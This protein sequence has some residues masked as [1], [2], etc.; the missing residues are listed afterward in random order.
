MLAT[1]KEVLIKVGQSEVIMMIKMVAPAAALKASKPKGNQ[2]KGET[3]RNICTIGSN[4]FII[5]LDD[6]IN[7]PSGMAIKLPKPKPINTL[8]KELTNWFPMPL[9][10]GP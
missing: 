3:G 6:P 10:L 1:P 4:N 8:I 2:A 5:I 7:T 9:S